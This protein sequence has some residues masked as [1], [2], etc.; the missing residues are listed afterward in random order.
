MFHYGLLKSVALLDFS[1]RL[2]VPWFS[3]AVPLQEVSLLHVVL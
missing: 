1:R 2:A 3:L